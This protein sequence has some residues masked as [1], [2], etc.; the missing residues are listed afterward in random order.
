MEQCKKCN[1]FFFTHLKTEC[2]CKPFTVEYEGEQTTV[3]AHDAEASALKFA[4]KIN[5]EGDLMNEE[6]IIT[7]NGVGFVVGA[8]PDVHYT[9][10]EVK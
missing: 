5:D 1:D 8:E 6:E 2:G 3:Y 10:N 4:E 9:A 7:V